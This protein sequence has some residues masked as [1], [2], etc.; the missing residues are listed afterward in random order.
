MTIEKMVIPNI[1]YSLIKR[2]VFDGSTP[3]SL[4]N[5]LQNISALCMPFR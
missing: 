4:A 1:I 3:I 2:H 5:G